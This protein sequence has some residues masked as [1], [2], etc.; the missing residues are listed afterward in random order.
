MPWIGSLPAA[1]IHLLLL[2]LLTLWI[3]PPLWRDNRKNHLGF[4]LTL[5]GLLLALSGFYLA[6]L[7]SHWPLPWLY[8][9]LNLFMVLILLALGRISM[10]MV[11]RHLR[12]MGRSDLTFLARPP[13]RHLSIFMLLLF[14]LAYWGHL[15]WPEKISTTLT[16]WLALAVAAAIMNQLNDWHRVACVLIKRHVLIL[17][18]CTWLLALGYLLL[19]S[20]QLGAPWPTSLGWHWLGLGALGLS[21]LIV[22]TIAGRLHANL[23]LETRH[24]LSTAAGLILLA[25]L[26]RSLAPF[27]AEG[28]RLLLAGSA[29]CWILAFSLYLYYMLPIFCRTGASRVSQLLDD[30]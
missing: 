13:F 1:I 3:A 17:Y 15:L 23:P 30:C 14:S 29:L 25:L 27:M 11:N 20:A 5:G 12:D 10:R 8:L 7:T 19:G 6:L 2:I 4:A 18:A 9:A 22:M 28:A 16:G 24:W 26:L 21:L